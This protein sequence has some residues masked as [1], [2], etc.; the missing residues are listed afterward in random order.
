VVADAAGTLAGVAGCPANFHGCHQQV[1]T[2][3]TSLYHACLVNSRVCASAETLCE[4][5]A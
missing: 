2:L 3:A 1:T 5:P 4:C